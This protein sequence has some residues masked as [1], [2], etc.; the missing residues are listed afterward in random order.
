MTA[1]LP[2]LPLVLPLLHMM[3]V[4]GEDEEEERARGQPCATRKIS[5]QMCVP[6][7][8]GCRVEDAAG[9]ATIAHI[10]AHMQLAGIPPSTPQ[11]EEGV[12][13]QSWRVCVV[14]VVWATG[15]HAWCGG[16]GQ[17]RS[18]S[19]WIPPVPCQEKRENEGGR[20]SQRVSRC[21]LCC[22]CMSMLMKKKRKRGRE[23]RTFLVHAAVLWLSA[24]HC[25][26]LCWCTTHTP[27]LLLLVTTTTVRH[28]AHGA[29]ACM[30][31]SVVS[32]QHTHMF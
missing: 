3:V 15:R 9:C 5:T 6:T 13:R 31:V 25:A 12:W 30:F 20:G 27:F 28:H 26:A 22:H 19:A 32:V 23:I 16:H 24:C 29:C 17:L 14:V 18:W 1:P 10:H 11:H 4:V 8:T 2:S 21:D 7:R